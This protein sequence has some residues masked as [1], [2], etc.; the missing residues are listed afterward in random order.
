MMK[1]YKVQPEIV[2]LAGTNPEIARFRIPEVKIRFNRGRMFEEESIT[3]SKSVYNILK[4]IAGNMIQTQ[5]M[6]LF[7]YLNRANKVLGYY[8][9]TIGG[10]A[11]TIFD[12][13]LILAG[14]VKCL[15]HGIIACHNHPSGN[16]QPSDADK[17]LT[18]QL[19]AATEVHD[20]NLLDHIIIAKNGY[21]SFSDE[22]LNGLQGLNGLS[23]TDLFTR[24]NYIAE[25]KKIGLRILIRSF[26]NFMN[27][28]LKISTFMTLTGI[29]LISSM[30]SLNHEFEC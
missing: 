9:H 27:S 21:F 23:G 10:T 6:G 15:A 25:V 17:R 3:S 29:L 8:R 2:L 22:G 26:L 30:A 5:E 19:K 28:S 24:E 16:I 12:I 14:A 7:L 13:K 1:R 4:K 11:G 18:K 20:I